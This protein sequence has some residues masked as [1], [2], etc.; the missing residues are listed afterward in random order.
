MKIPLPQSVRRTNIEF[1]S[2]FS[3][4]EVPDWTGVVINTIDLQSASW[5][6]ARNSC[7]SYRNCARFYKNNSI[8]PAIKSCVHRVIPV[9]AISSS[10]SV[11]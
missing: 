9:T 7:Y 11:I 10:V 5:L 4:C 1:Y 8:G 2:V 6:V 3:Q